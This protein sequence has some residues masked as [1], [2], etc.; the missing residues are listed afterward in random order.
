MFVLIKFNKIADDNCSNLLTTVYINN[1]Q[2]FMKRNRLQTMQK[3]YIKCNTLKK[4]K[5]FSELFD[6]EVFRWKK[7]D[8]VFWK[9]TIFQQWLTK[10]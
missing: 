1:Y 8:A 10:W 3:H 9:L 7:D 6:R 4:L 2:T 5:H